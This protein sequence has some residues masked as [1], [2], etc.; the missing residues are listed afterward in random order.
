MYFIKMYS[1]PGH[2][3]PLRGEQC[4]YSVFYVNWGNMGHN[5][6]RKTGEERAST[7][8]SEGG[9]NGNKPLWASGLLPLPY[10][11]FGY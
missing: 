2:L 1:V 8:Q 9:D 3:F 5:I 10:P 11:S 6:H 7:Y 4:P